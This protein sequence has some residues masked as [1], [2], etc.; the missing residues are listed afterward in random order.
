M[1]WRLI[2]TS[3]D[4]RFSFIKIMPL[5]HKENFFICYMV[6]FFPWCT[7]MLND[8]LIIIKGMDYATSWLHLRDA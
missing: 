7:V 6:N 1:K 3:A 8:L 5:E 4:R 2:Y